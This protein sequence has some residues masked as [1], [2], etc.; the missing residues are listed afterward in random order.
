MVF[1]EVVAPDIDIPV[2]EGEI[3]SCGDVDVLVKLPGMN[4]ACHGG[5]GISFFQGD[6]IAQVLVIGEGEGGVPVDNPPGIRT[7]EQA[8]V[9]GDGTVQVEG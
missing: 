5:D 9:P 6:G 7:P 1:Q 4:R 8:T 3:A 2:L